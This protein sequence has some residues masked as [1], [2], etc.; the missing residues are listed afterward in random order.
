MAV[1]GKTIPSVN[2]PF[3]DKDG[4]IN[5]IWHEFLRSFVE[6]SADGT[7][8]PGGSATTII[9]GNGLVATST[10]TSTTL[11]VGQGSGIAVN[12]DDV[13]VDINSQAFIAPALDDEVLVSDISDNNTIKKTQVRNIVGLSAPGGL[14]TQVQY[15]SGDLFAGDSGLTYN[16][17]GALT[18][19]S[20]LTI[21][22]SDFSTNASSNTSP[23]TFSV[24][25]GSANTHFL[26]KQPIGTGSSDMPMSLEATGGS[27]EVN[28]N[29]NA[30]ATGTV[31]SESRIRFQ[32]EDTVKWC[33]GLTS[34]SSGYNFVM[35]TTG[36]NGG[37]V[38]TVDATNS[39]F[40]MNTAL[41][42]K[43]VA[44]ITA[45]VTQTQGQGALTGEVNEVSTCANVND[46]VT[47]PAAIAGRMCLVINNG[48]QTLQVFPASGD[49][50]GAGVDTATTIVTT[51]RKLFMAFDS[52]NWEPV[53]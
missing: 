17:A 6:A 8:N 48:A 4:R 50:L 23:M 31:V 11:R 49:N 3:T 5:P 32:S 29:N 26:F 36:L 35:G 30:D 22:G 41:I 1:T 27:V 46:T 42:R 2:V 16:G 28:L 25:A 18:V 12:A 9:A 24:P 19:N 34:E 15:N 53:L 13:N 45:S 21:S 7:I 14:T 33:I 10:E 52:T 38:Y 44:G 47:L 51:S 39:F 20:E 37:V 43:T 40:T